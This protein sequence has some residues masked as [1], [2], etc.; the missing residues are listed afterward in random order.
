MLHPDLTPLDELIHEA[1][2]YLR[3]IHR[4]VV[5]TG[6][7]VSTPSG[8]PD[9]RST[10]SGLW[11][12]YDPMEVASLL[13]FRYHP[14]RF[15]EWVRPLVRQ[16]LAAEPNPAHQAIARLEQAGRV[17]AVITQNI[18]GLHQRAGSQQVY[19][20]HGTLETATCVRC[21]T[22]Y[23]SEVYLEDFLATG[24]VPHCPAC[25]GVLKPD[26]VLF[27]EQLPWEV[28]RAAEQAARS[29]DLMLVAGSSLEVTPAAELPLL[30]AQNG[31]ALIIV[32]NTPT[33]LDVR[34][35]VVIHADV[36]EVLPQIAA[37][38]LS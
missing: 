24:A 19:E 28:W 6:A 9:F 38:A 1:A 15:F 18:D 10:D 31:A 16:M 37:Q 30:A 13:S 23:P 26:V 2:E 35:D 29:C 27:G 7:G 17:Q 22:K 5:F 20:I 33:Y 14:E 21:Y 36:A 3:H 8:I 32:N 11:A 12:R 34:A 25:G 4:G